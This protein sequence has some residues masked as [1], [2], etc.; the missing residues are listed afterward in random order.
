[1][2]IAAVSLGSAMIEKHFTLDRKKIGMDNQMAIEPEEMIQL[3]KSCHNVYS[4]LGS[5]EHIVSQLEYAQRKKMRRSIIAVKD[6]VSGT[7]V[8]VSDLDVKRPGTGIPPDKIDTL[9]GKKLI[10]YV[11][12][13]TLLSE[14]DFA[15]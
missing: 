7:V 10:R 2:A 8:S 14:A 1:V 6:L 3:V 12:A 15:E 13:D 11:K 4:A 9:I 5:K